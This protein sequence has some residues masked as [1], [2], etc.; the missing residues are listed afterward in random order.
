MQ[1]SERK[2]ISLEEIEEIVKEVLKNHTYNTGGIIIPGPKF[3]TV[4]HNILV[5]HFNNIR[6]NGY[7]ET[8]TKG[9]DSQSILLR[10]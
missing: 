6:E 5:D 8:N 4:V 2:T 3:E 10:T 1:N 7:Q 9:K